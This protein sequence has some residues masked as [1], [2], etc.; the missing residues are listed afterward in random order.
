MEAFEPFLTP[1]DR[2]LEVGG[3]RRRDDAVDKGGVVVRPVRRGAQGVAFLLGT[4]VVGILLGKRGEIRSEIGREE[5]AVPASL[6]LAT[7]FDLEPAR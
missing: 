2:L 6:R 3:A 1:A 4:A 5:Q 7:L